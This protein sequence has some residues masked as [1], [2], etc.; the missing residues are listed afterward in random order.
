MEKKFIRVRTLK[1]ITIFTSILIIGFILVVITK[2]EADNIGGYTL[3]TIGV[4][5]ACFL[6]TGYMDI[7]TQEKY[8]KKNFSFLGDM[9]TQ[10]ISALASSPESIDMSQEGNGQVLKLSVYYSRTSGKAYLQL[11]VYVPH[12]YVPCSEMYEHE[13]CKVEN[14]LK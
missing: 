12:L 6:K 9:K 10:I 8:F 4:M 14:I 1:D 13:I 2:T 7:E 11:F 3:I 5:L